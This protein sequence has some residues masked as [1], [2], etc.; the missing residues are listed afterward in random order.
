MLTVDGYIKTDKYKCKYF[1]I[2]FNLMIYKFLFPIYI[3]IINT[4]N[5]KSCE[6]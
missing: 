2:H 1:K 4:T 6:S 3:D 5:I